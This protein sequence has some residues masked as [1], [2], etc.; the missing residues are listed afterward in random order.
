VDDDLDGLE[1]VEV[2]GWG[3]ISPIRYLALPSDNAADYGNP[4]EPF[5]VLIRRAERLAE[6]AWHRERGGSAIPSLR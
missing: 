2:R 1:V 5:E 4:F 6:N 3:S